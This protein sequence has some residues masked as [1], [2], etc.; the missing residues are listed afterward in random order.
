ML[1]Y[2]TLITIDTHN[3]HNKLT[4]SNK[5]LILTKWLALKTNFNVLQQRACAKPAL[6]HC[7]QANV[8]SGI[9]LNS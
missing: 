9:Y 6:L 7:E 4:V 2:N 1:Q 8:F 5:I 3:K